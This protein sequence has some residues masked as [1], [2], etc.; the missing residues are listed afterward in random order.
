MRS[1]DLNVIL[2][3]FCENRPFISWEKYN[4]LLRNI[5]KYSVLQVNINALLQI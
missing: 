3:H 4:C 5:L 1:L 2:R